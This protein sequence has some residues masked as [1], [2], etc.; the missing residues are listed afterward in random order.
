M[1]DSEDVFEV[2]A[3]KEEDNVF[4]V[5]AKKEEDNV[6]EVPAKKEEDVFEVWED[7]FLDEVIQGAE[8]ALSAIGKPSS[9]SSDSHNPPPPA[10]SHAPP[11]PT[12]SRHHQLQR[13]L[14]SVAATSSDIDV[15]FSPP[16]ELSQRS[17]DFDSFQHSPSGPA[18]SLSLAVAPTLRR[19]D[20][21][22]DNEIERLK[23]ELGQASKQLALLKKECLELKKERDKKGEQ[24][25]FVAL[26]NEGENGQANHS[27]SIN[28]EWR[29]LA[30]DHHGISRKIQNRESSKVQAVAEPSYKATGVQTDIDTQKEAQN[31]LNDE[32]PASL[33]LSEKLLAIWGSSG[34]QKLGSN[35]ISRLLVGCQRD[36]HILFGLMPINLPSKITTKFLTDRSSSG[37]PLQYIKDCFHT[38]EAT[39]VSQLYHMLTKIAEGTAVLETLFEPLLDLCSVKNVVVVHSSLCILHT[40]LKLLLELE[41]DSGRRDNVLVEGVCVESK[42]VDSCGLEDVRN[43]KLSCLHTNETSHAGCNQAQPELIYA[44][45]LRKRRCWNH[46][47]SLQPEVNWVYLF[48]A[49]HHIAM[50]MTEDSVRVEAVSTM[51]LILQRSNAY[52][53]RERFE[54]KMAFDTISRLLKRDVGL[55]VK[56]HA[57]RLLYLLLNCPKLLVNFCCGCKEGECASAVDD[58]ASTSGSL[59]FNS[60]LQGLADCVASHGSGLQELKLRRNAILVLAFLASSGKSGFDIFIGHRLSRGAIYLLLILQVLVSQVDQE[61]KAGE[62]LPEIFRE[63]TFLMREILILLNRLVSSPSYS[64]I[65]LRVLTST[66]DMASLTIDVANR[67]S[68]KCKTLN[69]RDNMVNHT[70]ETEI[71]DLGRVFKKRVF[72][73]LGDDS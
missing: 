73:Y 58:N 71:V 64:A 4:E 39:K 12:Q 3:K 55:R 56:Q 66:R 24:L 63:R 65:V 25:K 54:Q 60:I 1:D 33:E 34:E 38:P 42:V 41:N 47:N 48:E 57:L 19:L 17:S 67:L 7:G 18:K 37:V 26:K 15:S 40:Y 32:V 14:H 13:P 69:G 59:K 28:T 52:T 44:E 51:N 72:T 2:P 61:D 16:R 31:I 23:R 53:D 30:P 70:R 49:M 6:F 8:R 11:Q 50:K 35:V 43:G 45:I 36:F 5:P 9:N 68:K 20:K 21:D 22:K 46:R 27:K 29:N 10:T 62:E